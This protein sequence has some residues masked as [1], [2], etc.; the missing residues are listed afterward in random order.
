MSKVFS[1]C[2]VAGFFPFEVLSLEEPRI[3]KD[4]S[5]IAIA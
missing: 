1:G 2:A 4:E 5:G 3:L